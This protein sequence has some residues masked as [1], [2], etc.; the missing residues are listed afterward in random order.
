MSVEPE[1][2]APV[3]GADSDKVDN[4]RFED[5]AQ[6]ASDISRRSVLSRAH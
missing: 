4:P 1:A 2:I 6:R 5:R 3:I